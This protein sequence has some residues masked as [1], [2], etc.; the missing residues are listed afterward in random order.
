[1]L[2]SL[3]QL[4]ERGTDYGRIRSGLRV[5]A[6]ERRITIAILVRQDRVEIERVFYAG[7]DWRRALKLPER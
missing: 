3:D 1:L 4:P 5:L 2:S 6:F 7:Q